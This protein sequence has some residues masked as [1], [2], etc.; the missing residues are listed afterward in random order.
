[1]NYKNETTEL[2]TLYAAAKQELETAGEPL[3]VWAGGDAPIQQDMLRD[4]FRKRFPGINIEIIVDLSK[5]HDLKVYQQLNDGALEPDV[6]MLQTMNDFENWTKMGVLE[7][8]KSRGSTIYA[9]DTQTPTGILSAPLSLRSCPSMRK[10]E[11]TQCLRAMQI[12]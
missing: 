3:L 2:E 1:M 9:R 11:W 4:Q 12:S 8:F 7:P 5:Y 6:V 10:K